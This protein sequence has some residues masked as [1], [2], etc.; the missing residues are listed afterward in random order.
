MAYYIDQIHHT[1]NII[2]TKRIISLVPSQTELLIELGLQDN[3]IG[4]TKF[5][6]YPKGLKKT[7]TIVG[8]TKDFNIEK[9]NQLNPDLIIANKEEND[10]DKLEHLQQK[11]PVWTSDIISFDDA[12]NMI[13]SIGEITKTIV[14]ANKI[15]TKIKQLKHQLDVTPKST[16][17]V[18]YLIWKNPYMV[19]GSNNFINTMLLLMG[20]EN[21]LNKE[22][23]PR[24][25][26]ITLEN[27]KELNPDLIILSTE[28]YPF[29]LKDQK[30]FISLFPETT[31]LILS[32]E[33][34]SWYG[35]RMISSLETFISLIKD[36]L[37]KKS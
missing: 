20:W 10:K 13:Q 5:C 15:I 22:H 3:L 33:L 35:S 36:D 17:K 11:F 18:I 27:I 4:V 2:T 30:E 7:K 29:K 9:I 8:G 25:F 19:A 34:F 26:E 14:A 31:T 24:Y 1:L 16:L 32:G 12:I 6:I 37:L 23:L 21:V 28:P